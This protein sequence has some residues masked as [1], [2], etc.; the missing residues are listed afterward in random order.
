MR[1]LSFI[2]NKKTCIDPINA[3]LEDYRDFRADSRRI[4]IQLIKQLPKPALPECAKKLGLTK[5]GT[6]IINQDDEFA[7]A[8]DFCIHHF[9][10]AGKNVLQKAQEDISQWP[11]EDRPYLSAL[12]KSYFSVFRILDILPNKGAVLENLI[13]QSII[14]IF[15][16]GLSSTAEIGAII[17]GRI[18]EAQNF[19]CSSGI[20]IPISEQIYA[21]KIAP[22]ISKFYGDHNQSSQFQ[23]ST[24]QKAS[25]ESQIIRTSLQTIGEDVCFYNDLDPA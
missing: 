11:E 2:F 9:R 21:E 5:A 12:D 15:D 10:R 3:T 20:L 8:Y 22:I 16:T 18:L 1:W 17:I 4:N 19:L 14:E 24:G 25:L 23:L 7:L 13:S 6:I